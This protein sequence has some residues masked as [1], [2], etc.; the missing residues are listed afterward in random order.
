MIM[1]TVRTYLLLL[2]L[3]A[4]LG[5]CSEYQKLLKSNNYPLKLEKAREYYEDE[6]YF[7]S[8]ALLDELTGIYRGSVEAEEISFLLANC[9]FAQQEY[10]LAAYY[11]KTFAANYPYSKNAEDAEFKAAYCFYLIAPSSTLDQ[12]YTRRGIEELQLFIERYPE[13]S[14]RDTVNILSDNLH[15]RLENKAFD[16]ARLFYDIGNYK[17]SIRALKNVLIDF[18]DIEY[19]EEIQYYIVKSTFLL[20]DNSIENKRKERYEATVTE[21]LV[22]IDSYPDSKYVKEV[23]KL[24]NQTLKALNKL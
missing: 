9:H 19:R 23:E 6:D 2:L 14:R 13:S 3:I 10:T 18:P 20:A 5:S 22:L 21:Y 11:F 7:K 8:M 24:Y 16:N 12:T 17:A 1:K 15:S 4:V